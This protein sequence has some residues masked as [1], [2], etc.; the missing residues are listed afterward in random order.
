MF[1]LQLAAKRSSKIGLPIGGTKEAED[2]R[3][4]S[5]LQWANDS[6]APLGM[7]GLKPKYIGKQMQ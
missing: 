2:S 3:L 1:L 7:D 5:L 4:E 6:F